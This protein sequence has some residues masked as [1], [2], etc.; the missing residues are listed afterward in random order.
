MDEKKHLYWRIK[1][2]APWNHS[3]F[4]WCKFGTAEQTPIFFGYELNSGQYSWRLK[5]TRQQF[6]PDSEMSGGV[7]AAY[8]NP[9]PEEDYG[10]GGR[11]MNP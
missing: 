11:Q 3:S 6:P 7:R 2:G 5:D 10:Q 9:L 4:C 1:K 8:P